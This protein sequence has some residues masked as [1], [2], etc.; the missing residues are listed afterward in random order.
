[1][2]GNHPSQKGIWLALILLAGLGVA[3]GAAVL[4]YVAGAAATTVLGAGGASFMGASSLGLAAH[5]F[6]VE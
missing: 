4:F 5:R 2:N 1:M 3:A 6:M